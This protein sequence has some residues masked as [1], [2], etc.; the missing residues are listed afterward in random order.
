MAA[1]HRRHDISDQ[2]WERLRPLLPGAAGK[3]GR[4]AQDN[5]RFLDA[6]ILDFAHWGAV[7]RPRIQYGVDAHGMPVGLGL[8]QG[9]VADCTQAH[10]LIADLPAQYLLA[11]RG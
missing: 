9:T 4:P 5:R 3:R 10:A 1:A 6:I 7:A 11:D 2:V 8:T